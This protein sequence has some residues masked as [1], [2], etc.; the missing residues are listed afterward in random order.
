MLKTSQLKR[1]RSRGVALAVA[2]GVIGAGAFASSAGAAGSPTSVLAWNAIAQRAAVTVG[3][4]APS[5]ATVTLAQVQ[6][7]VYDTTV[8]ID[9]GRP[10]A[11][12]A[13]V[14]SRRH[15]SMDAAVATAGHDMLVHLF[16]GQVAALDADYATALAALPGVRAKDAGIAVGGRVAAGIIA[17]RQGD[18][19]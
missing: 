15:A 18:G 19:Y 6:A 5:E 12:R 3:K 8:A 1:T 2:A 14:P 4:Q 10:Y 13:H 16:P 17:L 11:V 9:G 7:A